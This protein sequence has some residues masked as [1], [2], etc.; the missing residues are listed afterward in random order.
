MINISC[1]ILNF[2]TT[3]YTIDCVNSIMAFTDSSFAYEIII[4]DNA[5]QQAEYLKLKKFCGK[6]GSSKVHLVRSKQNLGFGGG[7]MFGIQYS[8][9]CNYYAFIN[10]DTLFTTKNC[11][12]KLQVFMQNNPDAGICSPQMLDENKNFRVTIDHYS[13]LQREILRRPLLEYLFP[14][15]YLNR[16]KTYPEPTKVHYVQ[17]SFMFVDA[18]LFNKSGGFDTNLFLYYEESDLCLRLKKEYKKNTY[19]IPDL[20]YLHYKSASMKKG[21][22][23]KIEQKI[24][25]LY[26]TRKHY[27]WLSYKLL[28]LYFI[29][30]YLFTS[31]LKPSYFALLKILLI[32]APLTKSLKLKQPL[33]ME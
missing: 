23:I 32:G 25:L 7:N 14:K 9:R 12:G 13:S 2:N 30:R 18:D 20:T 1:I 28:L 17:G 29:I 27:G 31:I 24:S 22:T 3:G 8:S 4:V 33:Y 5:S 16:K 6:L 26:H 21:T 11:L 15:V 19:L 10:N